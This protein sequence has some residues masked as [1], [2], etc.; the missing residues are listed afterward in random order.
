[1][2]ATSAEGAHFFFSKL[3]PCSALHAAITDCPPCVLTGIKSRVQTNFALAAKQPAADA[4]FGSVAA[5]AAFAMCSTY[6]D[7]AHT[8][9]P[10]PTQAHTLAP[11][12][13]AAVLHAVQH[14]VTK[15]DTVKRNNDRVA[16]GAIEASDAADQGF[17]R[18]IVLLLA[19]TRGIAYAAVLRL[20][21][22]AQRETRC[23]AWD[24][25]ADAWCKHHVHH[26]DHS[27]CATGLETVNSSAVSPL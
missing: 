11:E 9:L 22:L 8:C 6:S 16:E 20:L 12:E 27:T 26:C 14:L 3:L 2:H 21:V 5:A 25:A 19:P 1:M 23:G 24:A 13:D 17:V 7:V 15:M 4:T 18:P 10:Y